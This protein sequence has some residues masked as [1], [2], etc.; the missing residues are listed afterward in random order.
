MATI[1]ETLKAALSSRSRGQAQRQASS[2]NPEH[3][4]AS[5]SE[6]T[7]YRPNNEELEE[8]EPEVVAALRDL[9]Y[10]YRREGIVSRRH[11]IRR[12]RQ[13]RLF[14]Q[15][16]QYN[17]FSSS[18]MSWHLPYQMSPLDEAAQFE[19]HRYQFV[20]NYFQAFGLSFIALISQDVPS[21]RAF[22]QSAQSE[23]DISTAKAATKIVD[24][25]EE[26]NHVADLLTSVGW[27]LWTDGKIGSYTRFVADGDRF[28]FR[29]VEDYD[30]ELV[31]LGDDAFLCPTCGEETVVSSQ[32]PVASGSFEFPVSSFEPAQRGA[33]ELNG[34]GDPES[35]R[36]ETNEANSPGSRTG[37]GTRARDAGGDAFGVVCRCGQPLSEEDLRPAEVIESPKVTATRKVPRGQEVITIVGGL[38]LNTPVWATEQH[39]YPYLQWEVE[40]HRARLRAAYPHAADKIVNFGAVDAED[41][42]SRA[43]RISVR[44]GLPV[45]HTGDALEKLVTYIRTWL[46]PWAFYEIEDKKIRQRLLELFPNGCYVAFAGN[47]YLESRNEKMDEHWVVKHA[48]PGDG[49]NR[50][51]VGSSMIE[52]QERYNLLSNIQAE[53]YEFGIPP[54]YADP[55]TLDFDA[56]SSQTAEPAAHY[57]ARAKPGM[58]LADSFFQPAPAVISRDFIQHQQDLVGPVAQ[59]LTGLFPAVYGGSMDDVKTASAYAQARDQAMGRLGMVWRRLKDFYARTMENA[60]DC[61]RKSRPEDIEIPILGEGGEFE[62][63]WIRQADLR[64]NIQ[65]RTEASESFPRLKNQQRAVLQQLMQSK[66]PEIARILGDPANITLI[67]DMIGLTEIVIPGEDS[68][69]KQMREI[70]QLLQAGLQSLV[71]GPQTELPGSL[72]VPTIGIDSV[73]DNHAIEF[74]ECVRWANSDAG[75]QARIDNPQGFENVRAHALLH[76]RELA[77]QLPAASGQLPA[78]EAPGPSAGSRLETPQGRSVS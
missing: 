19:G 64:G 69:T 68:R 8:R 24:L 73:F 36:R 31:K 55:E 14:W 20:T 26:N 57:P 15:G 32:L 33:N 78:K 42:Y 77:K 63:E 75:Q 1:L 49:Q 38:E 54:V 23:Q 11:E 62:S 61:F 48:L 41:V 51:A 43:S 52:I 47:T 5:E 39:E 30:T 3:E 56:L 10:N 29:E 45:A 59:M 72:P 7:D 70:A 65:M 2:P 67:K 46:R 60:V 28:G 50:P 18:D 53:T 9:I 12:I 44:Q 27:Y 16:L 76:K 6:G 13:A 35:K 74:G 40:A 25:I 22:P 21:V 17:F 58:S 34:S 66:D 4:V 71:L 37:T